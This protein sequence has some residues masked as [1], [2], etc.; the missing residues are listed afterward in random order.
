MHRTRIFSREQ[1]TCIFW[2]RFELAFLEIVIPTRINLLDESANSDDLCLISDIYRSKFIELRFFHLNF[3]FLTAFSQLRF[4]CSMNLPKSTD[5][6]QISD[7]MHLSSE[8]NCWLLWT[9]IFFRLLRTCI[10]SFGLSTSNFVQ[11]SALWHRRSRRSFLLRTDE[12][13]E[14]M[15]KMTELRRTAELERQNLQCST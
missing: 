1:R 12:L 3:D 2:E 8:H 4:F 15:N 10:F 9:R 14:N 5:F 6:G 11:N 13:C 7:F